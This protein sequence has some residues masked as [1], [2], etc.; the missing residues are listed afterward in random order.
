MYPVKTPRIVK[1][2]YPELFWHLDTSEKRVVLTFDDGPVPGV[3]DFVLDQLKT[4]RARALFFVVGSNAEKQS[5][6][7]K[8][9][10]DEGHLIGNH[11]YN[12]ISGWKSDDAAYFEN[13][14]LCEEVV[15]SVYFRPPY[16]RIRKSQIRKIK[17]QYSIVMWDVLSGDFDKTL[18]GDQCARNVI[19]NVQPGSVIVFHDSLKAWKRLKTALPLVLQNLSDQGYVFNFSEGEIGNTES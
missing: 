8:R 3:T 6:L 5:A 9:I 4:F 13:I 12:H 10:T 14:A 16:G 15:E 2:P 18:S 7:L 17:E 11:T 19:D 1:W